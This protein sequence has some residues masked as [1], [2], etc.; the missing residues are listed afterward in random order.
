M[1]VWSEDG[2][3]GLAKGYS[4]DVRKQMVQ[5]VDGRLRV[6]GGGIMVRQNKAFIIVKTTTTTSKQLKTTSTAVGFDTII[7][8]HTHHPPHRNSTLGQKP[9]QDSVS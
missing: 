5:R 3:W 1:G 6:R 4:L 8:V 9:L 7:T 2:E